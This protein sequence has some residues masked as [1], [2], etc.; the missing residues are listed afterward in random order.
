MV[1]YFEFRLDDF[2]PASS[3]FDK[4]RRAETSSLT[5]PTCR[6]VSRRLE[7]ELEV[8]FCGCEDV[9]LVTSSSEGKILVGPFLFFAFASRLGLLSVVEC[10]FAY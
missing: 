5:D 1:T 4:E 7:A 8:I 3:F 10:I 9:M 2:E 6:D